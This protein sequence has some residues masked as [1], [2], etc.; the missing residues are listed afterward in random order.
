M[1]HKRPLNHRVRYEHSHW[2]REL[3][4]LLEN[5]LIPYPIELLIKF[6]ILTLLVQMQHS[7]LL[8]DSERLK[9]LLL[10]LVLVPDQAC[11]LQIPEVAVFQ[12]GAQHFRH[13]HNARWLS[14]H[15]YYD[16]HFLVGSLA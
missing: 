9:N 2:D 7:I 15:I 5:I 13:R 14:L 3:V 1:E 12:L 4:L 11:L 10:P 16:L 8:V 6:L